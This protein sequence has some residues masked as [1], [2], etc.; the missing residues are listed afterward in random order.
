MRNTRLYTRADVFTNYNIYPC[1]PSHVRISPRRTTVSWSISAKENRKWMKY[2]G[3]PTT[4][5]QRFYFFLRSPRSAG[6][7]LSSLFPLSH[8]FIPARRC[9]KYTSTRP[10][11]PRSYHQASGTNKEYCPIRE[12]VARRARR[13]IPS[14]S[15][16]ILP[17]P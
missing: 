5:K 4:S 3:C 12:E 8:S 11:S 13:I 15:S 7:H 14:L 9:L 17:P 1:L 16:S 6:F 2:R 10:L